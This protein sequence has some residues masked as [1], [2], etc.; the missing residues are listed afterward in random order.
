MLN[1]CFDQGM[2]ELFRKL[3]R[4]YFAIDPEATVSYVLA[5]REIWDEEAKNI[6]GSHD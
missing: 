4:Y 6:G 2:L 5:Y 3:C 1:F